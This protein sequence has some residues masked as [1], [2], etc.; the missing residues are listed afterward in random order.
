MKKKI[1][2]TEIL[3]VR[4]TKGCYGNQT[5]AK[6]TPFGFLNEQ[7]RTNGILNNAGWFNGAGEKLGFGDLSISDFDT[8]AKNHHADDIFLVCSEFDTSW[9]MPNHLDSQAPGLDYIMKNCIWAVYNNRII[10]VRNTISKSIDDDMDGIPYS[11]VPRT[12]FHKLVGYG[13]KNIAAPTTTVA[14]TTPKKTISQADLNAIIKQAQVLMG[15]N[16]PQAVAATNTRGGLPSNRFGGLPG[17][18]PAITKPKTTTP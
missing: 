10:K 14:P 7:M 13:V 5:D 6:A 12:D 8:I 18:I 3:N 17:A 9:N 4:L 16:A 1:V 15:I 11:H 2:K